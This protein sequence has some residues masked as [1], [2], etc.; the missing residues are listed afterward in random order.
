MDDF[1]PYGK[2]FDEALD[3]LDKVLQ[4]CREMNLSLSNEKCNMMMN[5]GIVLGHHLSSR[6]IEVD[7]NKIKIITLLP[8]PLKPKD[9]RSFLGHAGY[10]RR[11]IKDFSKIASPLFT[12]LSK[13]VD[14]CWT[15]NC[16][17]DFETIKEKLSTAPV[18]QGPNW[19]L[20]FHIHT[21][22]SD[23][24]VGAVLGQN[25]DNKPYAI[26]FISKNL[27]G[28]ELNYTVTEK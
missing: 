5:E 27:V 7:K 2:S 19:A 18:L 14:Y 23:K 24:V 13:D 10:Y 12:L 25:E 15:L 16:Q 1:T 6:G 28:A 9:I 3:N 8:T 22:A 17:Q 21:D 4:R 20:P 26:Y 11:F